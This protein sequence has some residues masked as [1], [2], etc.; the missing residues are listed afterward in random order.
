ME[1][2]GFESHP[3]AMPG[4][5]AEPRVGMVAA[6]DEGGES[7]CG[8]VAKQRNWGKEEVQGLGLH[9]TGATYESLSPIYFLQLFI[10][11]EFTESSLRNVGAN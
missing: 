10:L 6:A 2:G 8:L 9:S 4:L 11:F 7:I 1:T 3:A 5:Q